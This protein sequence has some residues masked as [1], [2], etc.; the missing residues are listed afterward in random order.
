MFFI[1]SIRN[2]VIF[3]LY[4]ET[5]V[6]RPYTPVDQNL[7]AASQNSSQ[8]SDLFLMIKVYPDGMLS[9]YLNSLHIGES[10]SQGGKTENCV[11]VHTWTFTVVIMN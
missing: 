5:E 7:A 3:C 2:P 8:E 6:V 4:P 10:Q 1:V 9:S 11:E